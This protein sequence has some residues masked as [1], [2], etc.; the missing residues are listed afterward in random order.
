[1][2][3]AMADAHMIMP[4]DSEESIVTEALSEPEWIALIP[5]DK[6]KIEGAKA[7]SMCK[8]K[9][10]LVVWTP[11]KNISQ[12]AW[13]CPIYGKIKNGNQ[14]TNQQVDVQKE[15][16]K[17]TW[18]LRHHQDPHEESFTISTKIAPTSVR[19][20]KK[21]QSQSQSSSSWWNL[22]DQTWYHNYVKNVDKDDE[23]WWNYNHVKEN[24]DHD[25]W[26]NNVK[27]N[28]ND[29]VDMEDALNWFL[30]CK[31]RRLKHFGL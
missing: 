18:I 1:M 6:K 3:K 4:S 31:I 29:D 2:A 23:P 25:G 21:G 8:K 11:L 10:W 28:Q 16:W 27:K 9:F 30:Q 14:T 20:S 15:V 7:K 19:P 22:D 24:Q 26:N 5:E 13:L 17:G 12:L